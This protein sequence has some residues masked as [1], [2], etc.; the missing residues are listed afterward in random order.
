MATHPTILPAAQTPPPVPDRLRGFTVRP[1]VR[2]SHGGLGIVRHGDR[3][4]PSAYERPV[5]PA[6]IRLITAPT[7]R[8]EPIEP[9]RIDDTWFVDSNSDALADLES[10]FADQPAV[11]APAAEYD[12]L[13]DDI[14]ITWR[15]SISPW[16]LVICALPV[17]GGALAGAGLLIA[18][19]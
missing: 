2:Q 4:A 6:P 3:L 15:K 8:P 13:D 1:A 16:A 14:E 19:L 7:P 10:S 11:A 9:D 18:S 17:L 5:R 12:E